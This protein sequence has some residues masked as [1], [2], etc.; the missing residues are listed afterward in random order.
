MRLRT[1]AVFP[2]LALAACAPRV[3]AVADYFPL[4]VGNEW[5]YRTVGPAGDQVLRFVIVDESI[6]SRG[7]TQ[8]RL[9]EGPGQ[10]HFL[11]H[12]EIVG[13]SVSPGIWSVYLAGPLSRGKRFDAAKAEDFVLP[14]HE[15]KVTVDPSRAM[16]PVAASGYK[17]VTAFDRKVTV[18][19]GTF[20]DC[21]E[22]AHVAGPIT[23]VKY[24]AP[25]IGVV[26]AEA[27]R[28]GPDGKRQTVSKQ[29]LLHYSVAGRMGGQPVALPAA[30]GE[31][32]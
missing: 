26:Y 32:Q 5:T 22:V 23:G 7:E 24:F 13:M 28:T 20:T 12:G 8:F 6:G 29:E 18:P 1:L 4:K 10:K 15:G 27:W 25:D 14:E 16:V 30:T 3:R 2:L 21:L 17:L 31:P 19:A 11:R 9:S